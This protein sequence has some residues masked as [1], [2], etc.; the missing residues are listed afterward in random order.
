MDSQGI[1]EVL[2]LAGAFLVFLGLLSFFW[3]R[4][5]SLGK[6]PGDMFLQKGSFQFFFPIVTCIVV[7]I[8]LAV[9]PNLV[10]RLFR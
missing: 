7:S 10:F 3:Q 6:L 4:I 5:P 9:I 2:A 1:G 8:V